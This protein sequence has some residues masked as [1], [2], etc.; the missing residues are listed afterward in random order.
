MAPEYLELSSWKQLR[1]VW[2][3]HELHNRSNPI[4]YLETG[5]KNQHA[6]P[7]TWTENLAKLCSI[8]RM[9]ERPSISKGES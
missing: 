1:L 2:R 4:N 5:E 9:K 3:Q 8:Y 6:K 7:I